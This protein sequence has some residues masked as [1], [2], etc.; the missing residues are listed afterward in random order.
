MHLSNKIS[1]NP[2]SVLV[3][4]DPLVCLALALL[5]FLMKGCSHDE[6]STVCTFKIAG[7]CSQP[8]REAGGHS[9]LSKTLEYSPSSCSGPGSFWSCA[10]MTPFASLSSIWAGK[11][12]PLSENFGADH[13]VDLAQ[14]AQENHLFLPAWV[15]KEA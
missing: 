3:Q 7:S 6:I 4:S 1:E 15:P 9:G 12:S 14:L 8:Q 2:H 13:V 10:S 5:R 11:L